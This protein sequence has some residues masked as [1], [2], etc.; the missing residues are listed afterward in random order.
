MS[1]DHEGG[2]SSSKTVLIIV[3]V[4]A[5]VIVL[6][7]LACAGIGFFVL[8]GVQQG[9]QSIKQAVDDV[10]LA[11][12]AGDEFLADIA[13]GQLDAAA[14]ATSQDFLKGQVGSARTNRLK[15]L[16]EIVARN[17]FLKDHTSRSI[18][19]LTINPGQTVL[20]YSVTGP[21]KSGSCTVTVR[22]EGDLWKIDGFTVP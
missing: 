21:D 5:A 16:Q 6:I 14:E 4:I 2:S 15:Q 8:K 9:V 18:N 12:A 7:L 19:N 20:H 10:Q 13:A 11:Q 3:G 22:K 1:S 17:P